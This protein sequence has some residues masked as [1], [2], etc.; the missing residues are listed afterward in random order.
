MSLLIKR[1]DKLIL[2]C[3]YDERG[4]AR[5]A[6]GRWNANIRGWTF[7]YSKLSLQLVAD[8]FP[9]CD[10]SAFAIGDT[11][12]APAP[13]PVTLEFK[14][15]PYN[16]QAALTNLAV[17]L[18]NVFFFASVGTGKTKAAIDAFT[19]LYS[20]NKAEKCLVIC[21]H[22][23]IPNWAN[24]IVEHSHHSI[25][26][27]V[28]SID[29]RRELL[30]HSDAQYHIVNYDVIGKLSDVLRAQHYDM[31][32]ADECHGLKTHN[33]GRSKAAY[34]LMKDVA[35][36]I[37]MSG[38]IIANN[39]IDLFHPFKCIDESIFGPYITRFKYRYCVY[40]GY[41]NYELTG[42]RNVDELKRL[43][44]SIS[45]KYELDDIV[46]LPPEVTQV[47]QVE[48]KPGTIKLY[49]TLRKTLAM[50]VNESVVASTCALDNALKLSR[51]AS[52]SYEE[53]TVTKM[54][55]ERKEFVDV[56]DSKIIELIELIESIE[57]KVIVWARF[58][59]S[60]DRIAEHL[61]QCGTSFMIQDGR[62]KDKS[63]YLKYNDDKTKVWLSQIQTGIGY[64]I[65]SA[66]YAVFYELD[67][68]RT[69]HVQS[70]GR[71]RRLTGSETG[72]CIYIY[73]LGKDTID[74]E[75]YKALKDK[76]F[77]ADEFFRSTK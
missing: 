14:T 54:G 55:E 15:K 44:S 42:Y 65:P 13:A 50:Q 35:Y 38:T 1:D 19:L 17:E 28:G 59:H 74:E 77:R 11:K 40:G 52:G 56:D 27:I 18:K 2:Y 16:H 32:V 47:I 58:T 22:S 45:L 73:L 8:N 49:N 26:Q 48:L 67:Y 75:V 43:V 68:S 70:K 31:V 33:S 57:G 46:D 9:D 41:Q 6:G 53:I 63:Q 4:Q 24:E 39:Y 7:P 12:P 23:I 21:P 25:T 69:N 3:T 62:T 72:S 30:K 20:A 29:K 66:K 71:N 76:D 5:E 10:I 36:K 64:S 34:A 37:G 51:L 61:T 60:I